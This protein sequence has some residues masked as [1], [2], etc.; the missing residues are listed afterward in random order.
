[1]IR[2]AHGGFVAMLVALCAAF[3]PSVAAAHPLQFGSLLVRE[4]ANGTVETVFR[5]S[6]T[7]V[8]P[9]H[10][11][12]ALPSDCRALD[13]PVEEQDVLGTFAASRAHCA[14]GLEGRDIRVQGLAGRAC[15]VLVTFLRAD[16]SSAR[17]M[18][19][20]HDPVFHVP[21]RSVA[22]RVTPRYLALGIEHI[23]TGPD[24]LAFVAALMLLVRTRRRLLATITAF[25]VG[26]SVTLAAATLGLVHV[27]PAPVEASIALSIVLV[28]LELAHPERDT[29]TRRAPWLVAGT[30]GLLHGLGFAGA[31]AQVGL[32][33]G[34]VPLALLAFNL[35]VEAGQ[36]AFV[37]AALAL[38]SLARRAIR[39]RDG[40]PERLATYAIGALAMYWLIDRVATLITAA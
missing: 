22:P 3:L 17:A 5:F 13:A 2:G 28:A 30:F 4:Q 27:S 6:G 31:L 25:T 32:P 35:G 24:H 29:V 36:V 21:P 33:R 23:L 26:H 34:D 14:R 40:A 16:G 11:S 20:G 8:D 9:G 37:V 15:Q 7:E 38:A 10:A 19:D 12:V 18:I 1:M 39:V